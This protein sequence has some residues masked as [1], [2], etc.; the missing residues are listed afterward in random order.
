MALDLLFTEGVFTVT[1]HGLHVQ[2]E[3]SRPAWVALGLRLSRTE[4]GLA[5]ARADYARL[6]PKAYGRTFA[7]AEKAVALRTT[8]GG[9]VVSRARTNSDAPGAFRL[10]TSVLFPTA[11]TGWYDGFAGSNCKRLLNCSATRFGYGGYGPPPASGDCG[12]LTESA[13]HL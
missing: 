10:G 11:S 2:G 9:R 12:L 6:L 4:E 1:T 7:D 8:R 5:W 13:W 3:A